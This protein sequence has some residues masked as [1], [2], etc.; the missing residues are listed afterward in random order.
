MFETGCGESDG[1]TDDHLTN[2][3]SYDVDNMGVAT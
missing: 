3:V 1:D 2:F